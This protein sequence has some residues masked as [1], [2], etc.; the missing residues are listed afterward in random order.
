V[1]S[2]IDKFLLGTAWGPLDLLLIDMPP[3]EAQC[4]M[5]WREGS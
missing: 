1:N 2:A 4:L 5:L 3:G